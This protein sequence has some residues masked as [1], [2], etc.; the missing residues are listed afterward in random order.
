VLVA[1]S[2]GAAVLYALFTSH[3]RI[4][5]TLRSSP[6]KPIGEVADDERAKVVGRVHAVGELLEAPITGRRCVAY[7]ASVVGQERGGA[8][9]RETKAI[10]FV[11]E[12]GS[13]RA[14][15]DPTDARIAI[16]GGPTARTG[17]L[18][19]LTPGAA[20]LLY[21]HKQRPLR[22]LL[23]REAIVADG[24]SIAVLGSG[25]REPDPDA[26][27]SAAYR[28][29]A[30]TRLRLTSSRKYPLVISDDPQVTR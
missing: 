12:D 4:R 28:G 3:E 19:D 6:A 15:V 10:P 8:A 1:T 29:D 27:P 7:T 16:E 5:R 11:L 20:E 30:P 23:F 26:P 24:E 17:V 25:T 18:D 21:R 13:G 14:L 22:A 9:V 2:A